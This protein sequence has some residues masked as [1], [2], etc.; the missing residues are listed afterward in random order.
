MSKGTGSI[1]TFQHSKA[2]GA[3]PTVTAADN[4]V[5]LNGTIV[6]LGQAL[7]AVGNPANLLHDTEIPLNGFLLQVQQLGNKKLLLDPLNDDYRIGDIDGQFNGMN[8]IIA[9]FI[10]TYLVSNKLANFQSID[11]PNKRHTITAGNGSTGIIMDET[12]LQNISLGDA[13]NNIGT[14]IDGV[15]KTFAFVGDIGG[16]QFLF[17]DPV[18]PQ[19]WLGDIPGVLDNTFLFLGNS[20]LFEVDINGNVAIS[21]E[22][23]QGRY[24]FGDMGTVTDG[25]RLFINNNPLV[26]QIFLGTANGNAVNFVVDNNTGNFFFDNGAHNS[27]VNIN[28]VAGFTGTVTPVNSIT[29]NG[30]IVTAVS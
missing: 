25:L 20:N 23:A 21:A 16:D 13:V 28:G 5:S 8:V 29:V 11:Y 22:L 26:K 17:I 1:Q 4:G 12:V 3:P 14:V 27:V 10:D 9:D 18:T 24:E 30:G 15:A 6:E 19:Y 2:A 7:G